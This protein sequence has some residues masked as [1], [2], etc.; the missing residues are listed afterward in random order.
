MT[1]W[2]IIRDFFVKYVFGGFAS[3]SEFYGRNI[4]GNFITIW[5]EGDFGGTTV[6]TPDLYFFIPDIYQDVSG[7]APGSDLLYFSFGDYLSTTA[8]IIVLVVLAVIVA[9]GI[10][11][12]FRFL[13]SRFTKWGL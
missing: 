9:L 2:N 5:G 11:W 6:T 10:R 1:L 13:I 4:I 12:L 7:N 8:T 3:D